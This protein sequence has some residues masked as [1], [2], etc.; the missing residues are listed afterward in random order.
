MIKKI[1]IK[2]FFI[3]VS[4]KTNIKYPAIPKTTP[5]KFL[6]IQKTVNIISV[7]N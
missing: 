1:S 5:R 4:T 6:F 2:N 3:I 7:I